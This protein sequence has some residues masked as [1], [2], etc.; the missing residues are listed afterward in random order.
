[1]GLLTEEQTEFAKKRLIKAMDNYGWRIGTGF[2][3]TPFILEVLAE[4]D[5]DY[6]YKLLENEK[7]PGWLYMPKHGAT[8][9]WE[10]WEGA[11]TPD[12]VAA[13]LNHYSKGALC[14]W[15]IGCMCDI[16]IIGKN[17]F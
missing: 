10:N 4:I 13:S 3:S 6:A 17:Q 5:V 9:I 7:M 11:S 8:S 1:M 12:V 15:L 14:E 16:K 2:L